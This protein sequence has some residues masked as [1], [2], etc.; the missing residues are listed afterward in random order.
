MRLWAPGCHKPPRMPISGLDEAVSLVRKRA[1]A[2]KTQRPAPRDAEHTAAR[3]DNQRGLQHATAASAEPTRHPDVH[4]TTFWGEGHALN[5]EGHVRKGA[6]TRA[7][8]ANHGALGAFAG[9]GAALRTVGRAA[10][11]ARALRRRAG[12]RAWRASGKM[13][14]CS[15]GGRSGARSRGAQAA[16]EQR[17]AQVRP[18]G[19]ARGRRPPWRKDAGPGP[20]RA[21]RMRAPG[22]GPPRKRG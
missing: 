19:G 20:R 6:F 5:G 7:R 2:M 21:R 18:R 9:G 4:V 13:A 15:A 12:S 8:L 10:R 1:G 11:G 17:R 14:G 22:K 3:N 16:P